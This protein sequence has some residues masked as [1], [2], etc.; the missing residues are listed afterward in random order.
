[1]KPVIVDMYT[2]KAYVHEYASPAPASEFYP[3]W[4]KKLDK[5]VQDGVIEYPTMTSCEGFVAQYRNG[6]VIPLWSDLV[7]EFAPRGTSGCRWHFADRQTEAKVHPEAQRGSY[8]PETEYQHVKLDAPW[9]F[10][11]N[12]DISFQWVQPMWNFERPEEVLIPPGIV[13]F[14][15]Q[16]GVNINMF[17]KREPDV[18]VVKLDHGQ[19]MVLLTPLTERNVVYRTHLVTAEEMEKLNSLRSSIK[20]VGTYRRIKNLIQSGRCPFGG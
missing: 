13:N 11:C 17:V 10:T 6:L 16:H 7:M 5:T 15:Y 8:L 12:E 19:P 4:W 9:V 20:F 3:Q 14:K 18:R 1:M 2:D